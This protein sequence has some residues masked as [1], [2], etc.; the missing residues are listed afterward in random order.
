[1]VYKYAQWFL[2]QGIKPKDLVGFYMQN[3]PDFIFAWM[4]LW[5]IGA[6]PA[7]IN[8]NL[9]GKALLHCLKICNAKI[10]LVDEIPELADR[11]KEEKGEIEGVLGMRCVVMDSATKAEIYSTKPDR[12]ADLYRDDVQVGPFVPLALEMSVT[13]MHSQGEWAAAIFYTSGTTGMPKG[14]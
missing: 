10:I 11:I 7:M 14:W 4:A 13:L 8:Y 9:S 1:M 2:S 5:S 3:S 6:G 12:P